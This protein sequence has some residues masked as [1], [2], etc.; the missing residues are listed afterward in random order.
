LPLLL[1]LENFVLSEVPIEFV[2]ELIDLFKVD[3]FFDS[4]W[5]LFDA[6]FWLKDL[7]ARYAV[8][9]IAS[10]KLYACSVVS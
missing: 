3:L 1:P 7:I 5:H 10:I 2:Y 9:R 6:V 4:E 8:G